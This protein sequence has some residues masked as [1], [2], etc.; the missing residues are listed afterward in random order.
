MD[1][2]FCYDYRHHVVLRRCHFGV[3]GRN[4]NGTMIFQIISLILSTLCLLYRRQQWTSFIQM[5]EIIILPP[6]FCQHLRIQSC[7]PKRMGFRY[8]NE[9]FDTGVQSPGPFNEWGWIFLGGSLCG[10]IIYTL[11]AT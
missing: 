4:A 10:I 11:D 7:L 9:R 5:N 3:L 2:R 1:S 6:M 8:D